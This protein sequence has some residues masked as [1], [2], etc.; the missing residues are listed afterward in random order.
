M[1]Y[2]G[3]NVFVCFVFMFLGIGILGR[4]A[5]LCT[6]CIVSEFYWCCYVLFGVVLWF[7]MMILLY[8][9]NLK[10]IRW[11]AV[12]SPACSVPIIVISSIPTVTRCE[13]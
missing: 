9:V 8:G 4:L 2:V 12:E 10:C 3:T 6:S 5:I 7:S 1:K 11:Y 13:F